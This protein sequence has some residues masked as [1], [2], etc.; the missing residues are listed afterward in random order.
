MKLNIEKI[1]S[2]VSIPPEKKVVMCCYGANCDEIFNK[3]FNQYDQFIGEYGQLGPDFNPGESCY[4]N[5][6]SICKSFDKMDRFVIPMKDRERLNKDDWIL[7]DVKLL[8]CNNYYTMPVVKFVCR[9][10]NEKIQHKFMMHSYSH[11]MIPPDFIIYM[12]IP[13]PVLKGMDKDTIKKFRKLAWGVHKAYRQF[14]FPVR[15]FTKEQEV[16]KF[17]ARLKISI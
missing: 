10:I 12:Y 4:M 6:E 17:M 2:K 8:P 5:F 14:R 1:K 7:Y 9:I 13:E 16:P 11:S 15:D 3:D